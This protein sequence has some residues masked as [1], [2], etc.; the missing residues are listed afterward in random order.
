M[1][2]EI[3][4]PTEE[5]LILAAEM[6]RAGEL[7]AFPTETVYGLGADGLNKSAREKIYIAKGRPSEKPLTLHVADLEQVERV[8][9]ISPTAEKLFEKFCPGPLTI[10]LPKNKNLPDFVTNDLESVGIRFPA[11]ETALK[12][13]KFSGCPIAASSANISGETPPKNS[14][15]V[16]KNLNGRIKIILDGGECQFGISSTIIDLSFD[17]PKILRIGTISVD[18]I[19][20]FLNIEG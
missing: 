12:F 9:K 7:V 13:I 2:T 1:K 6:I 11:N 17:I 4:K 5:N 16:L 20:K 15:E 18:E 8:A 3:L 19:K 14:Q 10:I